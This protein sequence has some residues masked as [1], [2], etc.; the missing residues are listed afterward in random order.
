MKRK[1]EINDENEGEDCKQNKRRKLSKNLQIKLLRRQIYKLCPRN[2]LKYIC[3]RGIAR[4]IV[5]R[6]NVNSISEDKVYD[7][8][9]KR[10]IDDKF[11]KSLF[12]PPNL[13]NKIEFKNYA[14]KNLQVFLNRLNKLKLENILNRSDIF[15]NH[16]KLKKNEIVNVLISY[17]LGMKDPLLSWGYR[18]IEMNQI[19][20]DGLFVSG[21]QMFNLFIPKDIIAIIFSFFDYS[22]KHTVILK[23]MLDNIGLVNSEFYILL[24]E[25]FGF[26][27]KDMLLDRLNI[28][29]IPINILMNLRTVRI[30]TDNFYK[31]HLLYLK[32]NLL[33]IK[34]LIIRGNKSNNFLKLLKESKTLKKI[35]F[36]DIIDFNLLKEIKSLRKI[37]INKNYSEVNN[38][39][40]LLK[41]IKKLKF[42][43]S[44]RGEITH[45]RISNTIDINVKDINK[46]V[47]GNINKLSFI[48]FINIDFVGIE[49]LK[50]L[51]KLKFSVSG[52]NLE[53]LSK[54]ISELPSLKELDLDVIQNKPVFSLLVPKKM[55]NMDK[56]LSGIYDKFPN[57]ETLIFRIN[58]SLKI[59]VD[60]LSEKLKYMK[61]LKFVKIYKKIRL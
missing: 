61:R 4:A 42:D 39:S 57:L 15:V 44:I 11:I 28:Y 7:K 18:K 10:I 38:E 54:T 23:D 8:I 58:E 16:L 30:H 26:N 40:T 51:E 32:K 48:P 49:N 29:S 3:C 12:V 52:G 1:R 33:N 20:N 13:K 31:D 2:T 47:F 21:V 35:K 50:K 14:K 9:N 17:T 6:R 59:S 37:I 53:R 5:R 45:F 27:C 36:E 41:N 34:K 24:L 43:N 46:K 55:V 19:N 25:S 56:V 22:M 60:D